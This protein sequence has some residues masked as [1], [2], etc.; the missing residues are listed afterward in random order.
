MRAPMLEWLLEKQD[1]TLEML[2]DLV[3]IDSNS[4]DNQGVDRV[5][6]RFISFF[7]E[8]QIKNKQNQQITMVV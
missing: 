8:H 2:E 3:N 7:N 4:Y 1:D 6:A 5:G